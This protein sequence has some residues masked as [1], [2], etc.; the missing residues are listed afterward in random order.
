MVVARLLASFGTA[1]IMG[2]LWLRFG[3]GEWLRCRRAATHLEGTTPGT[4][5]GSARQHDFLHAGGFLV[6]GGLAAA[7]LNVVVPASGCRRGRENPVLAV[8]VM[9]VL[10]VVL[11]ICSEADAFVA[12]SLT[13]F[14]LTPRLA[15]LVV[16][17]MVDLK[18]IALQAGVFG[19]R[20]AARFAPTTLR[21]RRAVRVAGGVVAAVRRDVQAVL[22]VLVGGAL[23]RHLIGDAYLNYVKEWL[24][25]LVLVSGAV[26]VVLG[27]CWPS[28]TGVPWD[29]ED[30]A[31]QA[32][33]IQRTATRPAA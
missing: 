31:A 15:F 2:W 12:A 19:R 16:G 17:P 20:F 13:Q 26:L 6:I 4:P 22:L 1:V 3:R 28:S 33:P 8:L 14:S 18:L 10:A 5:S 32:A 25:P 23:L 27:L 29:S 30:A 7:V 9:A 21:R 11:S 24:G